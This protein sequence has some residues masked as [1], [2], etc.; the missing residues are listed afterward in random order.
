MV[1]LPSLACALRLRQHLVDATPPDAVRPVILNGDIVSYDADV[2]VNVNTVFLVTPGG[3]DGPLPLTGLV[4]DCGR[5]QHRDPHTGDMV[6]S[7]PPLCRLNRRR[8]QVLEGGRCVRLYTVQEALRPVPIPVLPAMCRIG[9]RVPSRVRHVFGNLL[10]AHPAL[11]DPNGHP[12]LAARLVAQTGVC[13]ND[14]LLVSR[15]QDRYTVRFV[16]FR[17]HGCIES[18]ADILQQVEGGSKDDALLP[19]TVKKT[20]TRIESALQEVRPGNADAL[21]RELLRRYGVAVRLQHQYYWSKGT[22]LCIRTPPPPAASYVVRVPVVGVPVVGE[23][24]GT[25]A[26]VVCSPDSTDHLFVPKVGEV[27]LE[28]IPWASEYVRAARRNIFWGCGIHLHLR[29]RNRL[30]FITVAQAYAGACARIQEWV[31]ALRASLVHQLT[32]MSC[33][34]GRAIVRSG[35]E[36]TDVLYSTES[37]MLAVPEAN[38]DSLLAAV[39][40]GAHVFP[41]QEESGTT[42]SIVM[43]ANRRDTLTATT[44][45][46][47]RGISHTPLGYSR[48]SECMEG[49]CLVFTY[50]IDAPPV[51]LS[52]Q[53]LRK[54]GMRGPCGSPWATHDVREIRRVVAR[55]NALEGAE[56]GRAKLALS[57][58]IPVACIHWPTTAERFEPDLVEARKKRRRL[59]PRV[60]HHP[61]LCRLSPIRNGQARGGVTVMHNRH[62][63]NVILHN[64]SEEDRDELE[65][66]LRR[67]AV[68]IAPPRGTPHKAQPTCPICLEPSTAP[69]VLGACGHVFCTECLVQYIDG[70]LAQGN[71]LGCP[72]PGCARPLLIKCILSLGDPALLETWKQH[73]VQHLERRRPDLVA[74]CPRCGTLP[75][76][77]PEGSSLECVEC[78]G[79]FCRFCSQDSREAIPDHPREECERRRLERQRA[80]AM[81]DGVSSSDGPGGPYPCP[82]CGFLL[83]RIEGCSHMTCT[84]PG[85]GSHHC[86]KCHREFSPSPESPSVMARVVEIRVR[87]VREQED[88]LLESTEANL[89][90][91]RPFRDCGIVEYAH[92]AVRVEDEQWPQDLLRPPNRQIYLKPTCVPVGTA[93]GEFV[94]VF[95]YIYDHINT[96]AR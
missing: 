35:G 23:D 64:G 46:G 6:V 93:L 44:S 63:P 70:L 95:T 73:R 52:T 37:T 1:F 27:S 38:P 77:R 67:I 60:I 9:G 68:S 91:D 86:H 33:M 12:R 57:I 32:D 94:E 4:V 81:D 21:R 26:Y 14:A 28:G 42:T 85:C 56:R 15:N 55:W 16:A 13:I 29:P 88:L 62:S 2:N 53:L 83:E 75:P 49:F 58:S 69:Q 36:V 41:S 17:F 79:S 54:L 84:I 19:D 5:V 3:E 66:T 47:Q 25:A 82:G 43:L 92:V 89:C 22:V 76:T 18:D 7:M 30:R 50:H 48:Q 51:E 34:G 40:S 31:E 11:F 87:L 20:I 80:M 71:L 74:L 96:C 8:G 45:L 65:K 90:K 72:V 61:T 39:P 59:M 10:R 24:G 78:H